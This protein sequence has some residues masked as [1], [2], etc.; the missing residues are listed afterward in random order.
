MWCLLLDDAG[1]RPA[2]GAQLGRRLRRRLS[3][4][5]PLSGFRNAAQP[6]AQLLRQCVRAHQR[7]RHGAQEASGKVRRASEGFLDIY[8]HLQHINQ[9]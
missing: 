6:G 2:R 7:E 8:H 9:S 4:A 5:D 3:R 1:T